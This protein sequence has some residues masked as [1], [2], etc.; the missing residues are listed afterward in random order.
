MLVEW[1]QF[2]FSIDSTFYNVHQ[3]LT[4]IDLELKY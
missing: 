4:E 2:T 3:Q 1:A